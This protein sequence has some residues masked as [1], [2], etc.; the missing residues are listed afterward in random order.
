M[1]VVSLISF[2]RKYI[3][4]DYAM[5]VFY[6]SV[7]KTFV[8]KDLS[9]HGISYFIIDGRFLGE[10][11]KVTFTGNFRSPVHSLALILSL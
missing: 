11:I 7:K 9:L 8:E 1:K 2:V 6:Y 5:D 4:D 10:S 3:E